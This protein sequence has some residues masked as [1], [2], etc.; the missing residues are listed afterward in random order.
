MARV[1]NFFN[2]AANTRVADVLDLRSGEHV[3]EVGFGGGAAITSTTDRLG[4][5]GHLYAIDLSGDMAVRAHHAFSALVTAHRLHLVCADV[6][7]LPLKPST[8]DHAY[9]IHSHIYWPDPLRG[10]NE[11]RRV[12]RPG[13]RLLLAM[14]TGIGLRLIR[15]FGREYQPTEP[16]AL[17]ELLDAA[18]YRSVTK[19]H[20][21]NNV[22]AVVG[23]VP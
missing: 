12:L 14:D 19:H 23:Q 8:V 4:S 6:S 3:L 21:T 17:I 18:G 5:E 9:A 22:V 7:A 11:L 2:S 15:L 20:L 10:V 1:L 13:G 16:P